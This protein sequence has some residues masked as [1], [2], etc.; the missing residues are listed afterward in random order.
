VP[1]ADV[2]RWGAKVIMPIVSPSSEFIG[3]GKPPASIADFKGLRIRALG[4]DGA[5]MRLVGA[6]PQNI[7]STEMYPAQERGLI[8][9]TSSAYASLAAFRLQEVS[10]W[11]TTNLSISAPPCFVYAGAKAFE[12][13]P[14]Q[15]RKLMMDSV[16][17]SLDYW[18]SAFVRENAAALELFNAKKLVPV[19]FPESDILNL[20]QQVQPIWDS[21][22]ADMDKRGYNGAELLKLMIDSAGKARV[23]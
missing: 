20:R 15:Y 6:A 19:T 21:W 10:N 16:P 13:L 23:S 14:P 17:V 2:A 9:A 18:E 8:N 22:V 11:Y 1:Q 3:A 12:G 5:A 7:P 4:G